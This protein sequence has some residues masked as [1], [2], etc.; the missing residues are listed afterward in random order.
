[1]T[2][3]VRWIEKIH[4]TKRKAS[5]L[6]FLKE[7]SGNLFSL[8]RKIILVETKWFITG[9]SDPEE[10]R[11]WPETGHGWR[12]YPLT[13]SELAESDIPTDEL[14]QPAL[15]FEWRPGWAGVWVRSKN[16]TKFIYKESAPEFSGINLTE[17]PAEVLL[18]DHAQTELISNWMKWTIWPGMESG[19][20]HV[21][22]WRLCKI[23]LIIVSIGNKLGFHQ[24]K[25]QL[26]QC[27]R[28][29]IKKINGETFTS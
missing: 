27:C 18:L 19:I 11:Y 14:H 5:F 17:R 15:R 22:H 4:Q 21:L 1:M 8:E 2:T 26:L 13:P 7:G 23:F 25:A 10:E 29:P 12:G 28:L 24:G 16:K 9:H 20:I 6:I 3:L